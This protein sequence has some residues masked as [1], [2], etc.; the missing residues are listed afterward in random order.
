[1]KD[2][3]PN[4]FLEAGLSIIQKEDLFKVYYRDN[5]HFDQYHRSI[6][7]KGYDVSSD[8]F[9]GPFNEC[10]EIIYE[11][12]KMPETHLQ[13]FINNTAQTSDTAYA[14]MTDN[15]R[16]LLTHYFFEL[17]HKQR[18]LDEYYI[19]RNPK[20]I[21]GDIIKYAQQRWTEELI[22]KNTQK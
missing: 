12:S 6:L 8:T 4:Q 20:F 13:F 22:N 15:L 16:V 18:L 11:K 17:A 14:S 9:Y 3:Y 5:A 21:I 2:F 7:Q 10:R 1:M 19:Q